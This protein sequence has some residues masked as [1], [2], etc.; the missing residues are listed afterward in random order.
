MTESDDKDNN[1]KLDKDDDDDFEDGRYSDNAEDN[2]DR[3]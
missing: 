2:N 1:H 3:K